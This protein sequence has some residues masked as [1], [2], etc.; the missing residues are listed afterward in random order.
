M[1]KRSTIGVFGLFV[2]LIGLNLVSAGIYF[3]ELESHYNLGDLVD[4]D[5]NLDPIKEGR[6]L[7]TNLLCNG[8][9]VIGF[10]N[11]PDEAGNVN[12]KLPL[13]FH[14]I[15]EANGNCYFISEY[16]GETREGN[17]FE[18][19]KLLIVRLEKEGFF[20]NPGEEIIIVGTVEKL[21]GAF[22]NGEVEISVPLLSLFELQIEE[23]N[24]TEGEGDDAGENGEVD[25]EGDDGDSME[26]NSEHEHGEDDEAHDDSEEESG[27][28]SDGEESGAG[29]DSNEEEDFI[30]YNAGKFYGKVVNGEFSI[31]IKL[32]NDAPA[33]SFRLDV[34]AYES[35][36]GV[37]TSEGI[38]MAGLEVFQ[39]LRGIDLAISNNN[40][41]PGASVEFKPTVLDQRGLSIDDE[42]SVV[43][44]D[45]LLLRHFEKIVPSQETISYV[46]PANLVSGY[47]EVIASSGDFEIIKKFFVNEKAIIS[48]EIV[49]NSLVVTNI[50]NIIYNKNIEV[51]LNG[52]PFVK[53][54][55]LELGESK[56]FKLTGTDEEYSVS[57]TDG[58]SEIT[59][60]GVMLTGNAVNVSEDGK[61]L[62]GPV[63]W[64]FLGVVLI[65]ALLFAFR[66]KLKKKSF[67]FH[68]PKFSKFG[69]KKKGEIVKIEEGEKVVDKGTKSG[70]KIMGGVKNVMSVAGVGVAGNVDSS[71]VKGSIVHN[72][73]SKVSVMQG[74][75]SRVSIVALKIKNKLGS[76]EKGSLHKAV[77]K[78]YNKRGA[79]YEQG[80]FIYIIF[81]PLMTKSKDNE[82]IAARA[83][84]EMV[85]VLN[86]HNKKFKDKIDFGI[87]V[88]NGEIINKI[89]NNKLK[90]TALG[91]FVVAAKR[92]AD[93][94]DKK[95]LITKEA[96]KKGIS[97]I[98]AE[99]KKVNDIESYEVRRVIDVKKNSKFIKD[100][101]KRQDK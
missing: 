61:G 24:F 58:E 54:V 35:L 30:D 19:S 18:I 28:N 59:R 80:N 11:F 81:S 42:V 22:V 73:A 64:I 12:I 45:E 29:E 95:V 84:Q 88:N 31:N 92:L 71:A 32:K 55:Y 51:E 68:M 13:N 93:S 74:N 82:V 7:K 21:N 50:G 100:F 101:L 5:I 48:F 20:A 43:I 8:V 62:G 72:E 1:K 65:I 86:A 26:S 87:G 89:E 15:N 90:F 39:V 53:K 14:T 96:Y 17:S 2:L 97:G 16:D 77:E 91:N 70:D 85:G 63:V 46:L 47:Y 33:G 6:L 94:S 66:H 36:E 27:E 67:A 3:S 83:A 49:N 56:R 76:A 44:R 4:L 69:K 38:V 41:D 40:Y 57:A 9:N 60:G 10:N 34:L 75:K 99:K 23:V 98:K 78:V 25:E 79:V 37:R 52:K